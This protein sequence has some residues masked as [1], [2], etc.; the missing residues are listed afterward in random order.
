MVVSSFIFPK[1]FFI[2]FFE[3][4]LKQT[5]KKSVNDVVCVCVY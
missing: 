5:K 4:H 1:I 3:F 2:L